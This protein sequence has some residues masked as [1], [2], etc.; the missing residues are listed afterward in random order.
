MVIQSSSTWNIFSQLCKISKL[1]K[2]EAPNL[3][4]TEARKRSP[5]SMGR[6]KENQHDSREL[7][8]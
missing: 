2:E 7:K 8:A 6:Q 3:L 1:L 4:P 5:V